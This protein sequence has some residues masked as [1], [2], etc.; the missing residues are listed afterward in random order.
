MP[1]SEDGKVE[2]GRRQDI[3]GCNKGQIKLYSQGKSIDR[4]T[5]VAELT[6]KLSNSCSSF[7]VLKP[8]AIFDPLMSMAE[9]FHTLHL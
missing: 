6:V 3:A 5:F 8:K 4:L 7:A 9:Q 1:I 2:D